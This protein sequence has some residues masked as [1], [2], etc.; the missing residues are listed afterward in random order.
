MI[1]V[2]SGTGNSLYVAELLSKKLGDKL[3]TLPLAERRLEVD[4]GRLIWVFPVYSWGIP[5]VLRKWIDRLVIP[6]GH[7]LKHYAVM[8]C[9]DDCGDTD[10]MWR[11]A[12]TRRGWHGLSAY[13]VQ[14]PNTYV[15]MKGFD[16]DPVE[17]AQ[18]KVDAAA[19]RTEEIAMRIDEES[20]R[21][22]LEDYFIENDIVRGRYAGIKTSLIYPW[23]KHFAMSPKPFHANDECIGCAICASTCPLENI[24]MEGHRPTWGKHCA[25]CLRCYH[26]CPRHAVAYGKATQGK[27]QSRLLI[28]KLLKS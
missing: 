2:F 6:N 27:G 12:L 8:T 25:L 14:M 19:P 3:V 23:F 16:V 11:T 5:P 7:K 26:I 15:L 9:G 18:A 28:G 20:K 24:K 1:I 21:F 4:D 17:L 13:S 22:T 10:S